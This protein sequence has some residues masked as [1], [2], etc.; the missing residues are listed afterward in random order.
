M[1]ATR[2][3]IA[4]DQFVHHDLRLLVSA[5]DQSTIKLPLAGRREVIFAQLSA[6]LT[7]GLRAQLAVFPASQ[8]VILLLRH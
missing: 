5:N 1:K 2:I 4:V 3:G 7:M 6:S 8:I